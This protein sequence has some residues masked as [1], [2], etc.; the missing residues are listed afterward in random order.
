MSLLI[1]TNFFSE[2]TRVKPDPRVVAFLRSVPVSEQYMSAL[3]IGEIGF[4]INSLP[5]GRRKTRLQSW[6]DTELVSQK[7]PRIL[8]LTL[9]VAGRWA[10]L[11]AEAGRTLP[12]IDSLIAATA[13]YHGFDLA[14]R[15]TKDFANLGLRLV[16]PFAAVP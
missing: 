12:I 8:P 10:K 4:G 9:E 16:D 5:A 2:V 1:D 7:G 6:L 3:T 14:T 15:N 11:K 13:L